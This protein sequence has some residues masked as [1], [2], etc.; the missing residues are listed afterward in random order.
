MIDLEAR[1]EHADAVRISGN[2]I[3]EECPKIPGRRQFA[4]GDERDI[5]DEMDL[6]TDDARGVKASWA[7][8]G[9]AAAMIGRSVRCRVIVRERR[10]NQFSAGVIAVVGKGDVPGV[11]TN[12]VDGLLSCFDELGIERRPFRA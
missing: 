2:R 9:H 11:A 3:G 4:G 12:P 8:N 6:G 1:Q 5:G 10:A 7:L